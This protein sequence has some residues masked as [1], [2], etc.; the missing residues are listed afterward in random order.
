MDNLSS[1]SGEFAAGVWAFLV[2]AFGSSIEIG[3]SD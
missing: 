2:A 3:G 1:G